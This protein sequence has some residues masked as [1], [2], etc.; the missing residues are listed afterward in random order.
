MAVMG[1]E[2]QL[3]AAL[4]MGDA[5]LRTD[6]V[7]CPLTRRH[8]DH[9][10][11]FRIDPDKLRAFCSCIPTWHPKGGKT[12][13]IWGLIEE[14]KGLTFS[15][16]KVWAMEQL[17]RSD[18]IQTKG[19]KSHASTIADLLAPAPHLRDD[20]LV[21]NYLRFRLGGADPPR[22]TTP[23]AGWRSLGYYDPPPQGEKKPIK[24]GDW[25]CAVFGTV[26]IERHRARPPRLFVS[27]R[28]RQGRAAAAPTAT[29]AT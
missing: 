18:L 1:H 5:V 10:K 6:H 19:K 14:L 2:L 3:I 7:I 20:G 24:V 28:P 17:G 11:S 23:I 22:P 8:N 13:D 26:D 16:A 29:R 9:N 12:L 15:D 21:A 4:G 25:P 27:R